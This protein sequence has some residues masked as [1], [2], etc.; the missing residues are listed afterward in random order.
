MRVGGARVVRAPSASAQG[1]RVR[2]VCSGGGSAGGPRAA[3]RAELDPAV[4]C[5][6]LAR[7]AYT[8][9]A[10]VV[11]R[12]LARHGV[13]LES[14]AESRETGWLL[15]RGPPPGAF[16]CDPSLPARA[17]R[18]LAGAEVRYV[19][20]RGVHWNARFWAKQP[21]VASL[22]RPWTTRASRDSVLAIHVGVSEAAAAVWDA[23]G[24]VVRRD[25]DAGTPV[26]FSGHSMGG[27]LA[28]ALTLLACK[29]VPG[30]ARSGL[31][32]PTHA[33]GAPAILASLERGT[34]VD[35]AL[36]AEAGVDPAAQFVT[37][38]LGVDPVPRF[39]SSS[40]PAVD[41]A[42]RWPAVVSGVRALADLALGDAATAAVGGFPDGSGIFEPSGSYILIAPGP[43]GPT[44]PPEALASSSPLASS[45]S[46]SSPS[47]SSYSLV[48]G[49]LGGLVDPRTRVESKVRRPPD[50]T[51]TVHVGKDAIERVLRLTVDDFR[52]NPLLA[53]GA[54][55]DHSA[56]RYLR[57][58]QACSDRAAAE[59]PPS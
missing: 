48:N 55:Q 35:A 46:S 4:T 1:W 11:A 8:Y 50:E 13:A 31:L 21:G 18:P 25:V 57:A 41:L 37:H 26:V 10:E 14:R 56:T 20:L 51:A 23:V 30:L 47:S 43:G 54:L 32:L 58:L 44:R 16:R 29:R 17:A 33:L 5:A 38:V 27:A 34:S 9:D 12:E 28:V 2:P 3:S 53:V 24:D 42:L 19:V 49:P 36:A 7:A 39:G 52:A 6:A 15:A 45:T 59:N 22:L 40:D